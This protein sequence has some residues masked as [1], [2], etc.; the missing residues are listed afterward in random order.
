LTRRATILSVVA[1]CVVATSAAAGGKAA[2]TL[3]FTHVIP[4]GPDG[5]Y[6][7]GSIESSKK[8]CKNDRKVAVLRRKNEG[9]ERIGTTRSEKNA[10]L[11]YKW[12]LETSEPLKNGTYFAKAPATGACKAD[13]SPDVRYPPT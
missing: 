11:G 10:S 4:A 3:H 8:A 6:F 12:V 7:E 13:K 2:T 5:S 9:N 1:A